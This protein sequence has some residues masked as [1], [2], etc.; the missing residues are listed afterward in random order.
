MVKADIK[1][2][3]YLSDID[4]PKI[5]ANNVMLL[6]S[7]DS[8]VARDSSLHPKYTETVND[9]I[10]KGYAQEVTQID[11]ESKRVWYL[12]HHPVINASKPEKLRLVFNCAANFQGISLNSQ[13]LQGPDLNNS[14]VGLVIRFRQEQVALAADVEAM[15]HQVHVLDRDCDALRFLWWPTYAFCGGRMGTQP[16]SL[17]AIVCK[18]ICLV[19]HHH[20]VVLHMP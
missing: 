14:L 2:L 15:F 17:D 8:P 5:D 18:F 16:N 20:Q 11:T 1:S 10:A 12:P 3:P 19:R 4:V 13:L 6:I 7:T 9:Y